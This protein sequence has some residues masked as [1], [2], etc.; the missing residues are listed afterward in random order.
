MQFQNITFEDG[1][2]DS[3]IEHVIQDKK[4]F[5]WIATR[6]GID[7]YNGQNIKSYKFLQEKQ[8]GTN[9]MLQTQK[10]NILVATTRGLFIFDAKKDLFELLKSEDSVLNTHLNSNIHTIIQLKN[11]KLLCGNANGTVFSLSFEENDG[12]VK[13]QMLNF[14]NGSNSNHPSSIFQDTKGTIWMGTSQGDLFVFNEKEFLN[15]T[16]SKYN[17]NTYIN[18]ITAD[19]NGKLWIGTKGNGLFNFDVNTNE[20]KQYKKQLNNNDNISESINNNFVIC[21]YA[22]KNDNIWIGTDGGGL[23]L[24]KNKKNKFYYFQSDSNNKFS[25]S[26][27]AILHI[28]PGEDNIIWTATVHG[29]LSYFKNNISLYNIPPS[30]LGIRNKDKQGSRILESKNGDLWLTAGRNGLR[31]YN[32]RTGKVTVFIS[33]PNNKSGLSGNNILSLYEDNQNR[34]WIGTLYGGLNILE[35][36]TGTFLKAENWSGLKAVFAIEKDGNGNIWVGSNSGVTVYNNNLKII[37][38]YTVGSNIGLSSNVITCMFKDVKDDMWVGTAK[39]LNVFK[40]GKFKS[41]LPKKEDSTSLSGSR[42]LS[43][44]E[45]DDL[46]ILVGTYGYGLNRYFRNSDNFKRIGQEKGLKATFIR[47]LFLDDEKNIWCSTNLGLSKI[48]PAGMVQ[49]FNSYDGIEPFNNN[50]AELGHNGY[51]YMAGNFGITY[52]K[53]EDLA[54][55]YSKD[56]NVFFTNISLINKNGIKE[57]PFKNYLENYKLIL[58]PDNVMFTLRFTTSNYWDPKNISYKYKLE[59]L[60][61]TWQNIGN[62]KTLSFSNLNPG[63]YSLKIKAFNREG[64]E[65]T[66][67]ATLNIYASP[68][69][70]EKTWVKIS[71]LLSFI[72][73]I[74]GFVKWR[75]STIK[76]Q[77]QNLNILINQKTKL[78]EAQNRKIYQN[79]IDLLNA[80]KA[81]QQLKQKQLENELNFKTNELTNRTLREIHKNNLLDKIKDDISKVAKQNKDSKSLKSIVTLID[82]TLNLDKDWDDFYNLF[83]QVQPSFIKNLLKE[84]PKITDRDIKL[85]ALIHLNFSS[86]HIATL[87]GI[88]ES[89]VKVARHRLRKKLKIEENQTFKEFFERLTTHAAT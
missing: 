25:I 61:E 20:V 14:S 50:K 57:A 2:S 19:S 33:D 26:D 88:S 13:H 85:C 3:R 48:T 31:R 65:S 51:I 79:N 81:N 5:V 64:L 22:D 18:D 39:G 30:K 80:E 56:H 34:I 53:A 60:H 55:N 87:F 62:N 76:K 82:N 71:L 58:P 28:S 37:N 46:S 83:Q 7:R 16:F 35:P 4:G 1:I 23:N 8:A 27:N 41:Y 12:N 73:I 52:F 68:S 32:R 78:V 43:I 66:H 84:S 10:G 75:V 9:T 69:F 11:G 67:I 77:K 29:G 45:D 63:D 47:G 49:N 44:A 24:Y 42:I 40:Q 36:K 59:G 21:L 6:L 15:T 89:S 54:N 38:T 70:W 72:A 17:H 86:Q 74:F